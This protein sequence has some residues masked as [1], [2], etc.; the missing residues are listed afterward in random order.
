M[1]GK[2]DGKKAFMFLFWTIAIGFLVWLIFGEQ[3]IELVNSLEF[4]NPEVVAIALGVLL[5]VLSYSVLYNLFKF[6]KG[7]ALLIGLI[8]GAIAAYYTYKDF[9]NGSD[10]PLL[11]IAVTL[12]VIGVIVKIIMPFLGF[13]KRRVHAPSQGNWGDWIGRNS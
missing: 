13:G 11:A 10:S 1:A 9:L 6:E 2:R 5:L 8:L 3:I 12:L 4:E 7:I